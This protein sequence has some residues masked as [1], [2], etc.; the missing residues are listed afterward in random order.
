MTI[1][2]YAVISIALMY[3]TSFAYSYK[4]RNIIH[5]VFNNKAVFLMYLSGMGFIGALYYFQW[6]TTIIWFTNIVTLI[7]IVNYYIVGKA[8][9]K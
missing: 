4:F 3:A 6:Y 7:T 8:F 2:T 5:C 9:N 1:T